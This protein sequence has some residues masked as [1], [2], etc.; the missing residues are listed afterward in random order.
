MTGFL[1]VWIEDEQGQVI[2]EGGPANLVREFSGAKR[3][4][5]KPD[6]GL[7]IPPQRVDGALGLRV[8]VR[9]ARP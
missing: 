5:A 4:T 9:G 1:A 2:A 6:G 8:L 7:V 3:L